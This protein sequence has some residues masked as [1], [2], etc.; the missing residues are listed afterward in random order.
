MTNLVMTS[1]ELK[2]LPLH[3]LFQLAKD[4]PKNMYD[5][6]NSRIIDEA[7]SRAAACGGI[8][9]LLR[10]IDPYKRTAR[11]PELG[12]PNGR[13]YTKKVRKAVGYSYP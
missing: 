6:M 4:T 11:S 10:G 2:E 13:S 1:E 9:D 12:T 3:E 5:V 7:S 8:L